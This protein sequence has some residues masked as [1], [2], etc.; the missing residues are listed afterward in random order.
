MSNSPKRS[1]GNVL[2]EYRLRTKLS[3][4]QLAVESNLSLKTIE[5]IE[6][7][8]A[9]NIQLQS[10]R[11]VVRTLKLNQLEVLDLHGWNVSLNDVKEKK[12]LLVNRY[13]NP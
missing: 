4:L 5:N 1:L 6:N 13:E 7:D 12:P 11:K 2:K 9:I 10:I 3:R 8:K